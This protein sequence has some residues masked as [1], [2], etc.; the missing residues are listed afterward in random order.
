MLP[1]KGR[2]GRA[3][4]AAP[5]ARETRSNARSVARTE[6]RFYGDGGLPRLLDVTGAAERLN[7]SERQMWAM[8]NR[9][10]LLSV[11]IGKRLLF[12]ERD[13]A[14]YVEQNKTRGPRGRAL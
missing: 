5:G 12:D 3:E 14:S 2:P 6:D 11:R 1:E 7:I 8:A 4:A 10:D 9:G 13:L